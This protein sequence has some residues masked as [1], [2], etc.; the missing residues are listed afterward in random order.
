MAKAT[1]VAKQPPKQARAVQTRDTLL[2][3]A[4]VLLA[5]VGIERIS[6]NLICQ[7]ANVSPPALYRYFE[8]K[9]AVLEA[10][11]LRLMERQNAVLMA[12]ID[13]YLSK[14]VELAAAH[15]EELL[16]ET[17]AITDT[18]PGGVWI[19]RA[20]HA[21]PRLVHI[22]VQSHRYVTDLLTDASMPH[23]PQLSRDALW[24]RIRMA[25]EFGYAVDE[26]LHEEHGI[27]KDVI[28]AEAARILRSA[29]LFESDGTRN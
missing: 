8:D 24:N 17:A 9:Y 26:L 28:F 22:R 21:A 1:M 16:R 19:E 18:E 3:V 5:E 15:V 20:L 6:T 27:S 10:L 4:G 13:R 14:G 2:E 11:G 7:R 23:L 25:V 12:W 29:L